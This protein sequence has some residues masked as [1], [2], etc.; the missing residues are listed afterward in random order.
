MSEVIVT[1]I[2]GFT[3]LAITL[4]R[5]FEGAAQESVMPIGARYAGKNPLHVYKC[6]D[7][8]CA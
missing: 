5:T 1:S 7:L 2:A 4:S 3:V 8:L 6:A